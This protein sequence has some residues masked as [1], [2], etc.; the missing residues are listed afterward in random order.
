MSRWDKNLREE[1]A[2][3]VRCAHAAHSRL[4]TKEEGQCSML[5]HKWFLLSNNTEQ[6][7]DWASNR[8]NHIVMHDLQKWILNSCTLNKI[9]KREHPINLP[10]GTITGQSKD[11]IE[12]LKK[13]HSLKPSTLIEC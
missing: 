12:F 1:A 9:Q 5:K 8:L 10:E 3:I 7:F 11:L 4:T 6:S 13:Y 2:P